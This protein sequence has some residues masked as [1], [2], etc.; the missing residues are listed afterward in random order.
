M[1]RLNPAEVA[2]ALP[3]PSRTAKQLANDARMKANPIGK[4]TKKKT[5]APAKPATPE[6]YVHKN[7]LGPDDVDPAEMRIDISTSGEAMATIADIEIVSPEKMQKKAENEA[8]M[9][10]MV[11]IEIE[12]SEDPNA[13]LFVGPFGHNGTNQYIRRGVPRLVK[14]KFLYAAIAAKV[15]RLVSAF[16]KDANGLEYN[17]LEGPK[18][19]THRV[20]IINDTPRGR[21]DYRRWLQEA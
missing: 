6:F 19:G 8:Y 2:A 9:N 10:E 4:R 11:E 16:G 15:A 12:G 17:R 13:P 20:V 3:A 21:E 14:R 18:L 7:L 5:S 1:P